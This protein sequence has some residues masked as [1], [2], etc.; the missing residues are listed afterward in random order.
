MRVFSRENPELHGGAPAVSATPANAADRVTVVIPTYNRP[1]EL[2]RLLHFQREAGSS[3]RI[4]VLDGSAEDVAA[5]NAS[6][7]ATFPNVTHRQYPSQLHFG[8]RIAEGLRMVTTPYTLICADDDFYFPAGVVEAAKFLDAHPDYSSAGGTVLTMR[9]YRQLPLVRGGFALGTDLDHGHRFDHGRFVNRALYYFAYTMIGALP[10]F[11]SL[12]RTDQ[13]RRAFSLVTATIKYSSVE[14][15]SVG[16]QLIEGKL[17]KLPVAFGVRD[18]S[19]VATRDAQ[20]DDAVTYIPRVDLDLIRPMLTEALMV[21]EGSSREL[22]GYLIDSLL[23]LW[24]EDS[25]Q[26][27]T[28]PEPRAARFLK[29]TGYCLEALFGRVAPGSVAA[30]RGLSQVEYKALQRSHRR[31]MSS[32]KSPN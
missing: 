14:L 19:T 26:L 28:R 12:R 10:L 6:T 3:L 2:A 5:S 30:L 25:Q 8:L 20:R 1:L 22:A 15:V 24:D 17:A 32:G 11:Y 7:C 18:Y 23:R 4:L 13:A 31:F 27:P 16:M 21:S 29:R 9:Y